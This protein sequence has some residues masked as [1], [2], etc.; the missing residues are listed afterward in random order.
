MSVWIIVGEWV[1]KVLADR[2]QNLCNT[3]TIPSQ[4]YAANNGQW[5]VIVTGSRKFSAVSDVEVAAFI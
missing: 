5:L 1:R 2:P 4:F 3:P